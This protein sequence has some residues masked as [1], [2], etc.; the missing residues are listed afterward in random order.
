MVEARDTLG[1]ISNDG[2][3]SND[4]SDGDSIIRLFH[5]KDSTTYLFGGTFTAPV[6]TDRDG[7]P[8]FWD[9]NLDNTGL[10]NLVESDLSSMITEANCDGIC[11]SV[12]T[13][14]GSQWDHKPAQHCTFQ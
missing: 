12:G 10:L 13:S 1:Y 9:T 4:Y 6:N 8:N 3:V 7:S 5:A 11:H 2:N 14:Y